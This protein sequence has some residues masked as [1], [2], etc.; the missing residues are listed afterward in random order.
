LLGTESSGGIIEAGYLERADGGTLF[1]DELADGCEEMQRLLFGV[2]SQGSYARI[3][4]AQ[5]IPIDV[6]VIA[7]LR[8]SSGVDR[9]DHAVRSDLLEKLSVTHLQVPPLRDYA[10][11][12]PDLLQ[13]FVEKLVEN[14]GLTYRR[15]GV[16]AQNRLRN[17]PWPGNVSELSNMVQRLLLKGGPEEIGLPELEAE[18]KP[19]APGNIP[20]V[21]QD[22]LSMPLREA[23]EQFERAYLKQQLLICHGKVGQLAKRVGMERTHLYRKLR[24]LGIDFRQT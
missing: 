11:D 17:Y 14:V 19:A 6:R 8:P 1:I 12:V 21:E 24:T 23:R 3:G 18:L 15:F 16:A 22:L 7:S 2:L 10:E 13:H 20:L 4:R 9:N 5:Q